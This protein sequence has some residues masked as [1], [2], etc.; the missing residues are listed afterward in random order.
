LA[1]FFVRS[2]STVWLSVTH[3]G[4]ENTLLAVSTGLG[5]LTTLEAV[6]LGS[7]SCYGR[8]AQLIRAVVAVSTT[9]TH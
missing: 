1:F 9:V 4:V 2:I 6:G 8:T 5:A 7:H 3:V